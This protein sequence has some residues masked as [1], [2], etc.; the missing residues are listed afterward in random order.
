MKIYGYPYSVTGVFGHR[1]FDE[2]GQEIGSILSLV[3]PSP[4]SEIY[5]FGLSWWSEYDID[6]TLARGTSRYIVEKGTS[7]EI[8][9]L[10]YQGKAKYEICCYG[11]T[12]SVD[13]KGETI[14]F[15]FMG[16]EIAVCCHGDC[17]DHQKVIDGEL[18]DCGWIFNVWEGL[19]GEEMLLIISFPHLRF[20]F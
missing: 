14:V 7:N 13:M 16:H 20:D 9:K 11:K 2:S 18:L 1:F 8:A 17:A 4:P 19:S 15:S 6:A 10:T 5:G 3:A 12:I